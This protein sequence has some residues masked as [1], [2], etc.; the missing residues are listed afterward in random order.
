MRRSV[1]VS[2]LILRLTMRSR[3]EIAYIHCNF[4][5]EER[6]SF[7]LALGT[8]RFFVYAI[9]RF[10]INISIVLIFSFKSRGGRS[11]ILIDQKTW[12]WNIFLLLVYFSQNHNLQRNFILL[13]GNPTISAL[14]LVSS[15]LSCTKI[16]RSL[17]P[18]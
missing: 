12:E 10:F 13:G 8:R 11:V 15:C 1:F 2:R 9:L 4:L 6:A 17:T 14:I 3:C 7:N 18:L 16:K 5:S